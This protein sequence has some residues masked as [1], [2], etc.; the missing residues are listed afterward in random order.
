MQKKKKSSPTPWWPWITRDG[1]RALEEDTRESLSPLWS[2]QAEYSSISH[3]LSLS[4]NVLICNRGDKTYFSWL[5][6]PCHIGIWH[7]E[8]TQ[9]MLGSS[10]YTTHRSAQ[11]WDPIL[12]AMGTV[13]VI[14]PNICLLDL[15]SGCGDRVFMETRLICGDTLLIVCDASRVMDIFL[16]DTQRQLHS[17]SRKTTAS[18]QS[19]E[20]WG[21]KY[22]K[23]QAQ[24]T[25]HLCFTLDYWKGFSHLPF[26]QHGIF[27][28]WIHKNFWWEVLPGVDTT[29]TWFA[30]CCLLWGC[31][32]IKFTGSQYVSVYCLLC[33]MR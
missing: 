12:R 28:P 17:L 31:F 18:R 30:K 24:I 22:K 6:L 27:W 13:G 11:I 16:P 21:E 8:I 7:T 9:Y 32:V 14:N 5:L 29:L 25:V 10:F 19:G 20:L 26:R 23:L 2:S 15:L 4:L 1:E 3:F 33:V